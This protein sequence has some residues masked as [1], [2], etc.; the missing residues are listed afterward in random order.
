MHL[1]AVWHEP[2]EVD[3]RVHA[4]IETLEVVEFVDL[5]HLDQEAIH[6]L[7]PEAETHFL[8]GREA[9]LVLGNELHVNAALERIHCR[10]I[11]PGIPLLHVA[12]ALEQ[13]GLR[14]EPS[15]IVFAY[16][17]GECLVPC[18]RFKEMGEILPHNLFIGID[19]IEGRQRGEVLGRIPHLRAP[20]GIPQ[21]LRIHVIQLARNPKILDKPFLV[22][23]PL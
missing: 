8:I 23:D 5:E 16:V 21:E 11:E 20:V 14:E 1:L 7:D 18:V 4:L 10:G 6:I 12:R 22:V 13:L 17:R 15:Q 2:V 19:R 9:R 3:I